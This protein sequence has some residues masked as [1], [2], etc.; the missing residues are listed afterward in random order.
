M[1]PEPGRRE[2]GSMAKPIRMDGT[3]GDSRELQTLFDRIAAETMAAEPL[4]SSPGRIFGDSEELQ[5]LFDRV[6]AQAA[7]A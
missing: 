3:S 4:P 5:A 1:P 7:S 6:A 2:S